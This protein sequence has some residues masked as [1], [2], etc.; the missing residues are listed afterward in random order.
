VRLVVCEPLVFRF[1][2]IDVSWFQMFGQFR[3]AARTAAE[4][5]DAT[6]SGSR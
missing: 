2:V 4:A 6:L 5:I 1:G 3:Q